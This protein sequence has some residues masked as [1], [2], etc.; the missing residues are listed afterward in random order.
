MHSLLSRMARGIRFAAVG[1]P[2]IVRKK[3]DA[4]DKG[5]SNDEQ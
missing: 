2:V 4:N 3:G 1:A 5:A